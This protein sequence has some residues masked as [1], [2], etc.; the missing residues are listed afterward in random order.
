MHHFF[1]IIYR[2]KWVA[3]KKQVKIASYVQ[4]YLYL[5]TVYTL[6]ILLVLRTR[7]ASAGTSQ[8]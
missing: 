2:I 6:S 7:K 4:N 5:E 8:K 3:Q 1:F